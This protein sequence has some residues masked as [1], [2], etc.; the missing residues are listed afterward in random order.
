M[1]SLLRLC[2]CLAALALPFAAIA[3]D[4]PVNPMA[5]LGAA[6]AA[7]GGS[8]WNDLRY[9]H[10]K[11]T[12]STGGLQGH[13]ERWSEF[14]T[15]R[16]L[17]RYSLGAMSGA[18]GFDGQN[19]WTQDAAGGAR[20]ETSGA[21]RELAV[22]AAYRDQLAFWFPSRHKAAIV[23]KGRE[24]ADDADFVVVAITPEGGREFDLWINA[25]T[26]L[27]ERLVEREAEQTRTEYYMDFREVHGLRMPFRVRA[28]R[29]DPRFDEIVT[30]D[31]IDFD[32]PATP[33]AFGAP[34]P[35]ADFRFPPGKTSVTVPL[36][37]A[38]GHLYVDAKLDGKG[39]LRLMID[40]GGPNV[41][42]AEAAQSLGLAATPGAT[43]SEPATVTVGALDI[44][45]LVLDKQAFASVPLAAAMKRVED[46]DR[47]GGVTGYELLRRFPARVDY[48]A[49]TIT[50][51]APAGWK[52]AGSGTR[53]ALRFHDNVPTVE[54]S[55][56][57]VRG[58][59]ALST[60]SRA[61]L[62]LAPAFVAAHGLVTKYK[63][64]TE[65]VAGAGVQGAAHAK[66]ARADSLK[67]G[68]VDVAKP[69][70]LLAEQGSGI[71]A[72]PSIAGDVGYG[73]LS[74]FA[75]VLDYA[76]EA[77]WLEPN[78]AAGADAFD[79]SG[80]FVERAANGIAVVDVVAGSPAAKAGL[81]AGDVIAAIDGAPAARVTLDALRMRLRA[82]PGSKV[83]LKLASGR[84][85][86]L[87]LR[88][89]V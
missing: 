29:G 1:K 81:K 43:A 75:V 69:V 46:V 36:T 61:S 76:D 80:A 8:T 33:V 59:F 37:I 77:A 17:L 63:A 52:Y 82:A 4:A 26:H 39:P 40:A 60:A 20:R 64:T 28:S 38:N 66:L 56:D 47:F 18:A 44:G 85:V 41:I 12:L 68:D 49:R 70:T 87:V 24:H 9:E 27:I 22:N 35:P 83:K 3:E 84:T 5:V 6:K 65:V 32:P 45:G 34:P 50:F 78:P 67:L 55:V 31:S 48:A 58:A 23:V 2:I 89:L 7:S 74:R 79:R 51:Y 71:L 72:D 11:V 21:A 16:S 53:V 86:T 15:G 73:V 10:S 62:T 13:V 19:G 42:A 57:G 30:V 25:D 88:D 14:L 54:G